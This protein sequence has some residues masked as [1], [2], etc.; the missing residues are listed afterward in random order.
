MRQYYRV[1]CIDKRL[2]IVTPCFFPR[3][4]TFLFVLL[5]SSYVW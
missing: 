1:E 2:V 5:V 4:D 3:C